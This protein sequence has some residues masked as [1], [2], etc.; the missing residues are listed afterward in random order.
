MAFLATSLPLQGQESLD[1]NSGQ[2]NLSREWSEAL[3]SNSVE[4][5]KNDHFM[6]DIAEVY[7]GSLLDGS[8]E[9]NRELFLDA[10]L[11]KDVGASS[12]QA[13]HLFSKHPF[14]FMAWIPAIVIYIKNIVERPLDAGGEAINWWWLLLPPAALALL[15]I[16]F[17][18]FAFWMPAIKK[19]LS[20]RFKSNPQIILLTVFGILTVISLITHQWALFC[21]IMICFA[22]IYSRKPNIVFLAGLATTLLISI[23]SLSGVF[24]IAADKLSAEDAISRGRV[25]LAYSSS[26]IEGMTPL[27]K[28][29]WARLNRDEAAAQFW[30]KESSNSK[31]KEI[32]VANINHKLATPEQTIEAY[33]KL[34]TRYP[35][36]IIIKFNLAQLYTQAQKISKA[37]EL[38]NSI[39]QQTYEDLSSRSLK[40]NRTL[41]DSIPEVSLETYQA[42]VIAEVKNWLAR[43]GLSPLSGSRALIFLL[44]LLV[45]WALLIIFQKLRLTASGLCIKTGETTISPNNPFS[46]FY[47]SA[48]GSS[49][50]SNVMTRQKLDQATQAYERYKRQKLASWAWYLPGAAALINKNDLIT[51]FLKT[52]STFLIAWWALSREFR[53]S[54]LNIFGISTPYQIGLQTFSIVLLIISIALYLF[55]VM[56]SRRK[57]SL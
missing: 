13:R 48:T 39:N 30:L 54:I 47:E 49:Y 36:D 8:F 34:Y 33:E 27:K 42:S 29:L 2:F 14:Q 46:P 9:K 53:Y 26:S 23:S 55:W 19:D 17:F 16:L 20:K 18:N 52:Y 41:L 4:K 12:H 6:V 40:L 44:Y 56:E 43:R 31:E 51:P 38:K 37:T 15:F 11:P 50:S 24:S 10:G 7:W 45:P 3:E 32:V 25:R 35:S 57:A 22:L 1:I 28:V 5:F 21:H